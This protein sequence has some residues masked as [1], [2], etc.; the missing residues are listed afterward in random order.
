[1]LCK[2]VVTIIVQNNFYNFISVLDTEP[3]NLDFLISSVMRGNVSIMS[4]LE[5]VYI[6]RNY[7]Q[8]SFL[9]TYIGDI[10]TLS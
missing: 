2:Y 9:L 5:K 10:S 1:M 4:S 8:K 7:V 3:Q 6:L